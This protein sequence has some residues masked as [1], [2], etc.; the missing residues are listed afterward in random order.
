V[1]L[2]ELRVD[3]GDLEWEETARWIL[4]EEDV[5]KETGKW[6]SPHV[7]ALEYRHVLMVK[8]LLQQGLLEFIRKCNNNYSIGSC[9]LDLV[10]EGYD[11][12]VKAIITRLIQDD[13][14]D[15][16]TSA[17]VGQI[18]HGRHKHQHTV[19]FWDDVK[20]TA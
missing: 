8:Q 3:K 4:Y 12:V 18:L 9:I 5:V 1:E 10:E 20:G 19:T 15:E 11:N 13:Q 17:L 14:I 6:G 7:A 16:N 2:E